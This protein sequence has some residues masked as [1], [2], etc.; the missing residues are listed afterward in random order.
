VVVAQ[1]NSIMV[2]SDSGDGDWDVSFE[3]F[4]SEKEEE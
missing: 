1:Y 4:F 3:F 2:S